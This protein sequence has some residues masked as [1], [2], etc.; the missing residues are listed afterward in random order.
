MSS[1]SFLSK[2]LITSYCNYEA[3]QLIQSKGD[4]ALKMQNRLYATFTTTIFKG[5]LGLFRP[6]Q[7][8][9]ILHRTVGAHSSPS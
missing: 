7:G 9:L 6:L 1:S 4:A 8:M 5:L 3:A 2:G